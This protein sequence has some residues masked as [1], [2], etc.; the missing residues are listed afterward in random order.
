MAEQG[1]G[2]KLDQERSLVTKIGE[3]IWWLIVLADRSKIDCNSA[4]E[5]FLASTERKVN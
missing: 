5:D 1:G 3:S 2:R 4:V